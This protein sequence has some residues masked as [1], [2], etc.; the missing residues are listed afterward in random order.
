MPWVKIIPC[1]D[2]DSSGLP[3]IIISQ[4]PEGNLR[5]FFCLGLLISDP[6]ARSHWPYLFQQG[7]G[8]S[9]VSWV[10]QQSAPRAQTAVEIMNL[11][12]FIYWRTKERVAIFHLWCMLSLSRVKHFSFLSDSCWN[13]CRD[14][15]MSSTQICRQGGHD[16][17]SQGVSSHTLLQDFKLLTCEP[18][19][20]Y[21]HVLF[22]F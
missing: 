19:K 10:C 14:P 11:E 15:I 2:W 13:R 17:V 7:M 12:S 22:L 8:T 18:L 6:C 16:L 3:K 4:S 20:D 9:G 21:V 1:Y 5:A